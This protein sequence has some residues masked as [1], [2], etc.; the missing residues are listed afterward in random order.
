MT[1]MGVVQNF[2][3]L[4]AARFFL[5]IFEAGFFP[6]AVYLIGFWYPPNRTQF[7]MS[8]F[9]CASAAS[10]AFSG[11]LAAAI[12]KMD[13]IANYEGW[14]WIFLLEGIASVVM[15]VVCFFLLPDSPSHAEG[16]WL[17]KD[18]ARFLNLSHVATRGVAKK[19]VDGE[20]KKFEWGVLGAILMDWQL[21]LQA[22]VFASNA[23]PYVPCLPS[24]LFPS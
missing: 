2:G 22:L 24:T 16:K 8:L 1:L 6:G 5:G 10:G 20:K 11:L 3:G 21:Y 14:R 7:R 4:V 12:A 13:G 19:V 23:V 15:G 17:T 9:Y 18:E